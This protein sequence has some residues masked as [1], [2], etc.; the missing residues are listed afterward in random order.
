MFSL[1]DLLHCNVPK[2]LSLNCNR[3]EAVE[4]F[5]FASTIRR[6]QG[7]SLDGMS[8]PDFNTL[9]TEPE[10]P[11]SVSK[12]RRTTKVVDI[13]CE[14]RLTFVLF[15]LCCFIL[16][17]CGRAGRTSNQIINE[18]HS[19]LKFDIGGFD[20]VGVLSTEYLSAELTLHNAIF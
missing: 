3:Y 11:G 15:L 10:N 2:D 5:M 17:F 9:P 14:W 7:K 13:D 18:K 16:C 1:D 19:G 6:I 20:S 8:I 4:R 12:E